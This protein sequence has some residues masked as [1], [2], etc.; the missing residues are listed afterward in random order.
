MRNLGTLI[1]AAKLAECF[2]T[3]TAKL[4][5]V[6]ATWYLPNFKKTGIESYLEGH[7]PGAVFFDIDACC[8]PSPYEHMLPSEKQFSEYVGS[9]GID[10]DTHVVV[11]NNHPDFPVFS[12]PR[13]W[14]TFRAFGHTAV[15]ILDGG[16]RVWRD[17]KYDI[18]TGQGT[19]PPKCNYT[20]KFNPNFIKSYEDVLKNIE[21]KQFQLIDA[22]PRGRFL[23]TDPEPRPGAIYFFKMYLYLKI[24]S[25]GN[26][27]KK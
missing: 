12:A 18:A 3:S 4:R 25:I 14:W 13:V 17:A 19:L 22:R 9:L 15:S 8:T 2:R 26:E 6:D 21:T 24:K 10:N 11:Y 1:S 16:M 7:I 27:N 20:A 23:G 5:V